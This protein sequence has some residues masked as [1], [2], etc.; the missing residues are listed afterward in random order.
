MFPSSLSRMSRTCYIWKTSVSL[1]RR[2]RT[3]ASNNPQN[4]RKAHDLPITSSFFPHLPRHCLIPS[5][6]FI[7]EPLSRRAS[8]KEAGKIVPSEEHVRTP[9]KLVIGYKLP[10]DLRGTVNT[11]L[12]KTNFMK[13]E[14]SMIEDFDK[15]DGEL[16][17]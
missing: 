12:A 9:L 2:N 6:Y 16:T 5:R 4:L 8:L 17:I 3:S 15:Q 11:F 13:K 10:S 14:T 1:S 7:R